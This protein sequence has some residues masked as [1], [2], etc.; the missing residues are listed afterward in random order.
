MCVCVCVKLV[1]WPWE[2]ERTPTKKAQ[3]RPCDVW[4][5]KEA[6]TR[7]PQEGGTVLWVTHTHQK[8]KTHTQVTSTLTPEVLGINA[9]SHNPLCEFMPPRKKKHTHAHTRSLLHPR[10]QEEREDFHPLLSL[11]LHSLNTTLIHTHTHTHTYTDSTQWPLLLL[12]GWRWMPR[13]GV[14][15][16]CVCVCVCV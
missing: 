13:R 10:Q 7:G 5:P 1:H 2:K 12:H 9:L 15:Y 6:K 8:Y 14:R 4:H 3:V 11:L 16:V